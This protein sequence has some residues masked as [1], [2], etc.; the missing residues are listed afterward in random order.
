MLL[1]MLVASGN[2][3]TPG[4]APPP[5]PPPAPGTKVQAENGTI[6]GTGVGVKNDVAGYEGS[7]FVGSFTNDGDRLTVAVSAQAAGT[8]SVN[9]RYHAWTDQLNNVSINGGAATSQSFPATGSAWATKTITGVPLSAGSNTVTI[10]K[11]WGYMDVDYVEVVSTGTGGSGITEATI[12]AESNE[13]VTYSG[14]GVQF[15]ND[16]AGYEG[17]GF[18]G[19]FTTDGD[20]MMATFSGFAAGTY[21]V[22]IR[23]H[24]WTDQQNTVVINGNST[25]QYFPA[26]GS[27]WAVKT[28]TGVTVPA[29]PTTVKFIKD[30]G[31]T[32]IDSIRLAP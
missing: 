8:F 24:A 21:T 3:W 10:L 16:V 23:Y 6:S 18:L 26:T 29:G 31:Y 22:S 17:T 7:G 15:K 19:S 9:I 14:S 12:Q 25:T 20:Q 2:W 4:S 13:T 5:P 30:W 1:P 11:D 28:I 32:D 27:G